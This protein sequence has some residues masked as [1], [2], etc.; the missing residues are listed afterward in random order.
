MKNKIQSITKQ[1][2]LNIYDT[3][4]NHFC[5][6]DVLKLYQ[7]LEDEGLINFSVVDIEHNGEYYF[8]AE[9]YSNIAN[10]IIILES[11]IRIRYEDIKDIIS[12]IDNLHAERERIETLFKK[13]FAYDEIK[14]VYADYNPS[15]KIIR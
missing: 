3:E 4:T 9:Y 11:D 8:Q 7:T 15:H 12:T 1:Y 13:A 5:N 6:G 14:E 2:N 10:T